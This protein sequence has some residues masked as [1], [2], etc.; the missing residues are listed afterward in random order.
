ME[1]TMLKTVFVFV[2]ILVLAPPTLNAATPRNA[3]KQQTAAEPTCID[4]HPDKREGTVVHPALDMGCDAC[5]VGK[6]AG[7]KPAPKLTAPVPDLCYTCHDKTAFDKK[8][9][10]A[11]V[12]SGM[13]GSCHNPHSSGNPKLLMTAVPDLC[14]SCH[15]RNALAKKQAHVKAAGGQC[16]TCH[17]PH[18]SDAIFVLT[19][20]VEDHC[21]SCH[22]GITARHV[23]ARI[24]PNDLHPLKGRPDPLRKGRDLACP[25]CHNPHAAEQQRISTKGRKGPEHLCLRCHKKTMVGP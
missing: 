2:F 9:L 22:D 15:E 17:D 19:R 3:A 18:G 10:H 7:E 8:T 12:A 21:E 23:M 20:L 4:C 13:C 24:S 5:H 14:L 11:P 16:L 25:S 6:H 1:K